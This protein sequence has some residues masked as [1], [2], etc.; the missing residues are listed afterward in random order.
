MV[1][2]TRQRI[3]DDDWETI[4]RHVP[5]VSVDLIVRVDNGV[6]LG[7]RTNEPAKGEWFTPGGRVHKCES[8]RD[9]V[10]RVAKQEIGIDVR[11]DR[12]IGTYEHIYDTADVDSTNSKHYLATGFVV[13]PEERPTVGDDQHSEFTVFD[14]PFQDLHPYVDQYLAEV[15]W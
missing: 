5:I 6:L 9:A 3:P 13:S 12:Q 15:D 4:V 2:E 10:H 8:R 1:D 14:P 7:K 11:I